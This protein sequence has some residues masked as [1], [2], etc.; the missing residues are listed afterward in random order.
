MSITL[1]AK[2]FSIHTT[3]NASNT[4]FS[5]HL[6]PQQDTRSPNLSFIKSKTTNNM[7]AINKEQPE[8]QSQQQQYQPQQQQYQPQYQQPA[9]VPH[10]APGANGMYY[11]TMPQQ[12][13]QLHGASPAGMPVYGYQPHHGHVAMAPVAPKPVETWK[14]VLLAFIALPIGLFVWK[15]KRALYLYSATKSIIYGIDFFVCLIFAAAFHAIMHAISGQTP[16]EYP[17]EVGR[18]L[19]ACH[20]ILWASAAIQA[21]IFGVY[22][23]LAIKYRREMRAE[24]VN[25]SLKASKI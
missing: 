12:Q 21:I 8:V 10:M 4:P 3:Y 1:P 13:Y 17:E 19:S 15:E 6:I 5:H 18:I 9:G 2:D 7:S 20:G 25:K 14:P 23:W 11:Q 24:E 16:D 22:T